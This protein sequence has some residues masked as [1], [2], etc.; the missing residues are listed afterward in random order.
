MNPIEHCWAWIKEWI[1]KHHPELLNLP[2]TDD[3]VKEAL[4][5]AIEE[6]WEAMSREYVD[7]LIRSMD[8]RINAVIE[9]KGWHTKY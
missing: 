3:L 4:F 8:S 9:A 2:K 5:K 7:L 6:A 1:N